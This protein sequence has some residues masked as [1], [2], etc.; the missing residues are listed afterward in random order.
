DSA[1]VTDYG[2]PP[3]GF[4]PC[5]F[6]GAP[7]SPLPPGAPPSFTASGFWNFDSA[8]TA[9]SDTYVERTNTVGFPSFCAYRP[10]PV[11]SLPTLILSV[12]PSSFS[13]TVSTAGLSRPVSADVLSASA[14][15]SALSA[16]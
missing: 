15:S 6:L 5:G 8:A 13:L 7:P 1:S 2:C 10:L 9:Q 3:C 12:P 4:P 16:L 14:K 11:T